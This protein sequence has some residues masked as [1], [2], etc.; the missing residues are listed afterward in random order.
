M[1]P[2]YILS[3]ARHLDSQLPPFAKGLVTV[4]PHI[5]AFAYTLNIA[6]FYIR[7]RYHTLTQRLLG[8]G[9]ITTVPPNPNVRPPSYALLGVL[10]IAKLAHQVYKS[11]TGLFKEAEERIKLSEKARGKLP[12]YSPQTR[13]LEASKG[14]D[15]YLDYALAKDVLAKQQVEEDLDVGE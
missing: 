5:L 13:A 10:V 7:G 14:G 2:T 6:L 8:T 3:K 11:T 15:I 1:F 4:A 9:Y 12:E